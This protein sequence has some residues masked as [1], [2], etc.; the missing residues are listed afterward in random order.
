[1]TMAPMT[2]PRKNG[3]ASEDEAN[4]APVKA[5]KGS[6]RRVFL[7]ANPAPRKTMA[8]TASMSGT[9]R[10]EVNA[11]KASGKAVHKMT[12]TKISHTWFASHTGPMARSMSVRGFWPRIVPPAIRSQRPPPRSA[13][14][15]TA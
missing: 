10:I 7:N 2:V 6:W 5:S 8:S 13:P 11:A 9:N 15:N 1:M 3:A 12:S 4:T 14:P